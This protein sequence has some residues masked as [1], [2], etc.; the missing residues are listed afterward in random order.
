MR[1][2]RKIPPTPKHQTLLPQK[3]IRCSLL[4]T[5][6]RTPQRQRKQPLHPR[7]HRSTTLTIQTL[8]K[9]KTLPTHKL[10]VHQ[11]QRLQRM[12]TL[13]PRRTARH[14]I[15]LIKQSQ[16][17]KPNIALPKQIQTPPHMLPGIRRH[18]PQI[19]RLILRK[20][21]I[22]HLGLQRHPNT[23][24][25]RPPVQTAHHRQHAVSDLLR[26]QPLPVHPPKQ[27]VLRVPGSFP[28]I[29]HSP[30]TIHTAQHQQP[31]KALH[32]PAQPMHIPLRPPCRKHCRK[33]VQKRR[34]RRSSAMQAEI[35][36]RRNQ[37]TAKQ[38]APRPVHKHPRR[39]WILSRT[40][41]LRQL[42]PRSLRTNRLPLAQT[43]RKTRRHLRTRSMHIPTHHQP[44]RP[45]RLRRLT[46][47][48]S[49]RNR[50]R[51]LALYRKHPLPQACPTRTV[52]RLQSMHHLIPAHIQLSPILR[53]QAL[54][55][56]CPLFRRHRQSLLSRRRKPTQ[57]LLTQR[58]TIRS[59]NPADLR[60]NRLNPL[61]HSLHRRIPRRL[62]R[63]AHK[64]AVLIR[65]S[66]QKRLKLIVLTLRNRIKLMI[67]AARTPNAQTQNPR[68]NTGNSL[69]QPLLPHLQRIQIPTRQMKRTRTQKTGRRPHLKTVRPQQIPRHLQQNKPIKR[70]IRIQSIHNPVSIPPRLRTVIIMLITVALRKTHHIQPVLPPTLTKTLRTQ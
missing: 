50:R 21:R 44:W 16:H 36:R 53:S 14:Q 20:N 65:S 60:L 69:R 67:M 7:T 39:Q 30:L 43:N 9:Q 38:P 35:V 68:P 62:L 17:R 12:H 19:I 32:T 41:P 15:R 31:H 52:L 51:S 1:R 48:R 33:P 58:R 28:G 40:Q 57:L 45:R 47:T 54:L 4:S 63:I 8:R 11:R 23:R 56:R 18:R 37:P 49:R 27:A 6:K 55:L 13:A 29:I 2:L 34:V 64:R 3:T 46:N 59:L 61:L 26:I 22:I 66:M 5:R 24:A 10:T 70:H 42:Q 25:S